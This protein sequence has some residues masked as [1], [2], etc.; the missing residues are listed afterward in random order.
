MCVCV[1]S[2]KRR[3]NIDRMVTMKAIDSMAFHRKKKPFGKLLSV[4]EHI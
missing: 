3:K 2:N 1:L 4:K